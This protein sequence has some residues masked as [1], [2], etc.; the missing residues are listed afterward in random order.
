MAVGVTPGELRELTESFP[1]WKDTAVSGG[2]EDATSRAP[3]SKTWYFVCGASISPPPAG[4]TTPL[5]NT[6]IFA[7]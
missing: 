6:P 1:N 3:H 5:P 7:S 2:N 4:S